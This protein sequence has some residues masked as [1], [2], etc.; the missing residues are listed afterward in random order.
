MS[1]LTNASARRLAKL[2]FGIE[3]QKRMKIIHCLDTDFQCLVLEEIK[4]LNDDAPLDLR[5]TSPPGAMPNC[6]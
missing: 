5:D 1:K 4:I 6:S 3:K 2:L